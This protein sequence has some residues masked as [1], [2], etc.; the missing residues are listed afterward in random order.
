VRR[1]LRPV[2]ALATLALAVWLVFVNHV[3]QYQAGIAWSFTTGEMWLQEPGFHV[4]TP[5]TL[6]A[7]V[8][9]RPQRV[10]ITSAG[11]A[12]FNCKLVQFQAAHWREFIRVEGWRYYWL[13][14]RL[15]LNL[16]YR[17]EYRGF[18]DILRGYA[19]S[20]QHYPF[21]AI[22]EEFTQQ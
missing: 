21:V 5:W 17:E 15:S 22:L 19:F 9:L 10:C 14:N 18:R 20:A 4:T 13:A 8:D 3:D 11:H 1:A 7:R 16:G 12:A 2:S 6:V